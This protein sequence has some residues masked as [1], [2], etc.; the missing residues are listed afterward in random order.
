MQKH[1][2]SDLKLRSDKFRFGVKEV[3]YLGFRIDGE[4]LHHSKEKIKA[5]SEAQAPAKTNSTKN[6]F[7]SSEFL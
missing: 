1:Q 6:I 7:R 3:T 5:I 2:N 4:G